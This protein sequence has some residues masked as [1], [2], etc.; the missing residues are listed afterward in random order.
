[1]KRLLLLVLAACILSPLAFGQV[2]TDLKGTIT[3]WTWTAKAIAFVTP[4]F[5]KLYPNIN[6]DVTP[7]S[8]PDTHDKI[9]VAIASGSGAPDLLT[10]DSAYI[11]KFIEQ[12][13]LVDMTDYINTVKAKFP[14]YK[15]A[16]DSA[17]GHVFAV[18]FDCGPVGYYYQKGIVDKYKIT[19]P[20]TW[21]QW[22][23]VGKQLKA[24]G[25]YM[26][27][28]SVAATAMDQSQH[29]EVGQH[30]LLVQQ[31]GGAY[32]DENLRPTLDSK[33]SVTA[34]KLIKQ[35]VDAGIAANVE[36]GAPAAYDMFNKGQVLGVISAAWYV[37]VLNNFV[38][39]DMAQFG[40]WRVAAMPAFAPGG[41]RASNL[42]GSELAIA[43]QTS[44]E[45]QKL[46]MAFIKFV[47]G[48]LEGAKAHADYGEF[49]AFMPAWPTDI[50]QNKTFPV[51]G[52]QK[53]YK[54]FA[55]ITP[56][57]PATWRIPPVYTQIQ[58][59]LQAKMNSILTNKVTVEKG[60]AEAQAEA[61]SK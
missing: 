60:L 27:T 6:V 26:N 49:P 15:I 29:G 37:N 22:M 36:Q 50:V 1:M 41:V 51:L 53:V 23:T 24:K 47:C 42:G 30:S 40:N 46:A 13:G 48:S 38:T 55:Q 11:Q 39:P 34:M 59:I 18:P 35:M 56:T 4:E 10:I 16:N 2:N 17:G 32:F 45:Q 21:A 61:L 3:C 14:A 5:Q 19:L 12:G 52:D 54:L 9:F 28:I 8:H 57:V 20:A 31:Q 7:M 44:D 25:V 43:T 33:E 58:S